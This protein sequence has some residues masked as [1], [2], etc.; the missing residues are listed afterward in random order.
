MRW[1]VFVALVVCMAPALSWGDSPPHIVFLVAEREY[2]T[3]ESL[4]DFAAS[5]L[6]EYRTTF[7]F[8]DAKDRNR[9]VGVEAVE[10]ADLLVISVR[11]RTLPTGQLARIRACI[12]SGTPVIGIRTASH[13]FSLRNGQPEQGRAVWAEFDRQVFG[14]N[15]TGHHGNQLKTTVLVPADASNEPL[16][17]GLKAGHPYRS[18]GSLYIVS[19]LAAGASVLLSGR[20]EGHAVEPVAWT[21]ERADGGRSFYTSLGHIEDFEGDVLPTVLGHAIRWCLSDRPTVKAGNEP[22]APAASPAP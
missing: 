4:T 17:A 10:T 15:Y 6:G 8:E 9:L 5:R 3:R 18:G 16:L 14:G 12:E 1:S 13:A 11:R 22:S 7:V 19:P 21:F 20:V 2:Q